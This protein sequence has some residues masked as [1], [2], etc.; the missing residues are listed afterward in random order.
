MIYKKNLTLNKK[1]LNHKLNKIIIGT[2]QFY[3]NY[4]IV[5][6]KIKILKI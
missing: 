2:A 3:S 4:G 1:R 6:K 5:K